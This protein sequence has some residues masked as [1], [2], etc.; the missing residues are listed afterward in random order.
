MYKIKNFMDTTYT[1]L[2]PRLSPRQPGNEA[3]LT[4]TVFL[5]LLDT[6]LLSQ[7]RNYTLL[8]AIDTTETI[9]A[10]HIVVLQILAFFFVCFLFEVAS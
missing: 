1:S 10:V 4:F 7:S 5:L 9:A 8:T 2:V 3:N 6:S